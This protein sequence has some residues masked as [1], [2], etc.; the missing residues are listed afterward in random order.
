MIQVNAELKL[1]YYFWV[2]LYIL[3]TMGTTLS[4]E[5][6]E[7]LWP[8]KTFI[9]KRAIIQF[10]KLSAFFSKAYGEIYTAIKKTGTESNEPPFAIYFSVNEEKKETDLAAA[11]PV[12]RTI[13]EIEGFQKL[14][15]PQSKALLITYYGSYENMAKAYETLEKYATDLHLRKSWM[16][17]QYFSDPAIEKNPDN[18]K[19]DIYM[20]VK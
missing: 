18:W 9:T 4:Y 20:V 5:V 1:I 6:K 7:V 17:E 11:V 3:I 13:Q 8:E 15:I 14:T 16:L 12:Q 2:Y 10:D 19:T